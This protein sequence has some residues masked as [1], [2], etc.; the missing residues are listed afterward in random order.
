V[1]SPSSFDCNTLDDVESDADNDEIIGCRNS[2]A[3]IT[4]VHTISCR[5]RTEEEVYILI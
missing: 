1:L 2:L 4:P 5:T 3:Y